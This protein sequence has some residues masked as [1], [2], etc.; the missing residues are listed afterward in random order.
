ME[1]GKILSMGNWY[2]SIINGL[3]ELRNTRKTNTSFKCK[4]ILVYSNGMGER[5]NGY[6]D[7]SNTIL[8]CPI[9]MRIWINLRPIYLEGV[10]TFI[11]S[12]E[13]HET[14]DVN[15][16][17]NKVKIKSEAIISWK[18]LR[19]W[20]ELKV[21]GYNTVNVNLYDNEQSIQWSILSHKI[22]STK[23]LDFLSNVANRVFILSCIISGL[24][25]GVI[26]SFMTIVLMIILQL[27]IHK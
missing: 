21:S 17:A 3:F 16:I 7:A 13:Y 25:G 27:V 14:I 6:A 2:D 26:F 5:Y 9:L 11:V 10:K 22:L 19:T 18:Y 4:I 8:F 24:I 1:I 12:N 20:M 15:D 23:M